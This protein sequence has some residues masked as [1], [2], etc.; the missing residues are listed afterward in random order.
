M[1]LC[2]ASHLN[3]SKY[4]WGPGQL[5]ATSRVVIKEGQEQISDKSMM[6]RMALDINRLKKCYS[7]SCLESPHLIEHPDNN[8]KLKTGSLLKKMVSPQLYLT[9]RI[10][11]KPNPDKLA[12]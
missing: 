4:I 6:K 12:G 1:P 7:E 2:N 11:R 8:L 9:F 3:G 5:W 10:R